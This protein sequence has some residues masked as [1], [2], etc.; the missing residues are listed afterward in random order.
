MFLQEN[1]L[2][3]FLLFLCYFGAGDGTQD[4][5][6]TN[7]NLATRVISQPLL[8]A[9]FP[10]FSTFGLSGNFFSFEEFGK[11]SYSLLSVKVEAGPTLYPNQN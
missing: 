8:S 1:P 9:Q 11:Q 2:H 7:G 6:H 4:C 5:E 10:V 3:N